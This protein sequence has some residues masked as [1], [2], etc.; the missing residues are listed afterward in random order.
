MACGQESDHTARKGRF[1]VP[2]IGGV[3]V[4]VDSCSC[5][6]GGAQCRRRR[7][8]D[9]SDSSAWVAC[10]AT[11][12]VAS[13][14]AC[15]DTQCRQARWP[16][17]SLACINAASS[18]DDARSRAA[19]GA[20]IAQRCE[21]SHLGVKCHR[22]ERFGVLIIWRHSEMTNLLILALKN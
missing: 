21:K 8:S 19:E 22:N 5:T 11:A 1:P 18:S 6:P 20:Q 4:V 7:F 16:G 15:V 9:Y 17:G 3:V 2:F 13:A 14:L 10:A 12:A